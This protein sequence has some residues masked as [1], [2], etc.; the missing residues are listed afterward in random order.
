MRHSLLTITLLSDEKGLTKAFCFQERK[1]ESV[2]TGPILKTLTSFS[3]WWWLVSV[4][5]G[6]GTGRHRPQLTVVAE[7]AAVP[8]LGR[9]RRGS[10]KA[11]MTAEAGLQCLGERPAGTPL[12]CAGSRRPD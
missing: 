1:E 11:G 4:R 2:M 6:R 10:V 7:P 5:V 9:Q 8:A 12:K 3:R